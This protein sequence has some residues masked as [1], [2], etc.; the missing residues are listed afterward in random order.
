MIALSFLLV[1]AIQ[2]DV[3]VGEKTLAVRDDSA[4]V[5]ASYLISPGV[6][7]HPTPTGLFQ[8]RKIV[9]NPAWV[10]PRKRWA[11]GRRPTPPAD[12]KNP[13]KVVKIFFKEPDY[14]I[15]GTA[16]EHL[17][18]DAASHGCIRMAPDHAFVLARLAME[19]G[20]AGKPDSWYQN[21]ISGKRSVTVRVPKPIPIRITQ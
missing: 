15:H 10:P 8:I 12:P 2:V 9:W 18:G 17:L 3:S 21:V 7:K 19:S 16:E 1:A 11:W 4:K 5:I 20:G 6:P 13:M 14:Y